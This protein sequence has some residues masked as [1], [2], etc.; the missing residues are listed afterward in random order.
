QQMR[1]C[2]EVITML[3]SIHYLSRYSMAA[4]RLQT[5][6]YIPDSRLYFKALR[7][8]PLPIWLDSSNRNDRASRYDIISAS[9]RSHLITTRAGTQI[10]TALGSEYSNANPFELVDNALA[11]IQL[12]WESDL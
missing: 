1:C 10:T 12:S 4:P 7:H 5:L 6:P 3:R 9:P 2:L 8:L 11:D